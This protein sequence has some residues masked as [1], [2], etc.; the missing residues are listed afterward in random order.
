[1]KIDHIEHGDQFTLE[2]S[3]PNNKTKRVTMRFTIIEKGVGPAAK[4]GI[5]IIGAKVRMEDGTEEFITAELLEHAIP[6]KP[7]PSLTPLRPVDKSYVL[8]Q[9]TVPR[10]KNGLLFI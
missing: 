2:G 5:F 7:E 4:P 3:D 10:K 9:K 8:N 1:M 6:I